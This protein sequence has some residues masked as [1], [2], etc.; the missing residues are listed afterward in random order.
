MPS[1]YR[2]TN[3]C[4]NSD[5]LWQSLPVTDVFADVSKWLTISEVAELLDIPSGKVSRLLQEHSLIAVRR[6]S[7]Q[8][9]PADLIVDGEPLHSLKGTVVLLLDSG[10]N[11][12]EAIEWLYTENDSLATT[13]IK[14]LLA[15]RRAEIRRLAQALAL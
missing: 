3:T 6:D 5:A 12:T 10:F 1:Q 13:P 7:Q 11:E 8:M 2:Y 15:G 14:A 4:E 9:I